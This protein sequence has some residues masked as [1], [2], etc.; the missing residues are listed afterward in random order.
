MP[1][2][3]I[4]VDPDTPELDQGDTTEKPIPVPNASRTRVRVAEANPPATIAAHETADTDASPD[5]S[6]IEI[7]STIATASVMA[8]LPG[9]FHI[10]GLSSLLVRSDFVQ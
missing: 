3:R 9:Y 1:A 10:L 4:S 8:S 6:S 2:P 7:D 5:S